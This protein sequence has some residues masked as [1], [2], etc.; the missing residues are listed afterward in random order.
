MKDRYLKSRNP[1]VFT[2]KA[3][4][5]TS[6]DF[7]NTNFTGWENFT[8]QDSES[9]PIKTEISPRESKSPVTKTSKGRNR[10]KEFSNHI[11]ERQNFNTSL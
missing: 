11:K 6:V 10:I 9:S 8:Y 5:F 4:P 2:P 1:G 7:V 3:Q